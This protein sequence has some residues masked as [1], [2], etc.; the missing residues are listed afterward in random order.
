MA[1]LVQVNPVDHQRGQLDLVELASQQLFQRYYGACY[2]R[3]R[4]RYVKTKRMPTLEA[5]RNARADLVR[6]IQ[7]GQAPIVNAIRLGAGRERL[8]PPL[9]KAKR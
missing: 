4:T 1:G 7:Q 2:D 9:V 8:Y 6:L 5:A 3:A